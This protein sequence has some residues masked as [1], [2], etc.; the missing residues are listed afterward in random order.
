MKIYHA[1]TNLPPWGPSEHLARIDAA[2]VSS[3]SI[4]LSDVDVG[5]F[6][7]ED[8]GDHYTV[9]GYR[10]FVSQFAHAMRKLSHP[11]IVSDSTIDW[12][13]HI[14]STWE[15]TGWASNVLRQTRPCVV[16]AVCGS[17]FVARAAHNDHFYTRV[18]HHLRT[19]DRITDVVIVG[20]WN[21]AGRT[22]EACH[23]IPRLTSLV[24]RH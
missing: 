12:H 24:H 20:G 19:N 8:D 6:A 4:P 11:L 18:S 5:A 3:G 23:A 14:P 2:L 9:D 13:N 10:R 15:Y 1:L 21:D 16:D 22:D 7:L 17:G